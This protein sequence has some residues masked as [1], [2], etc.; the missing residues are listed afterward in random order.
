MTTEEFIDSIKLDGEEWRDVVGYEGYYIVSNFGRIAV[1]ERLVTR[2]HRNGKDANF[3]LK[4]HICSTSIAPST[5]YRR[6]TFKTKHKLK[7]TQLVHR[8]VAKAFLD[9]PNNYTCVDHI[10]DNPQNNYAS[11]LQWCDYKIN[12]AKEHHR[13]AVSKAKIGHIDPKR[14]PI[15]AIDDNNNIIN[16]SSVWEAH[17][18]GHHN[19]AILK[20]LN[21]KLHTHH[22]YK[23]M[24]LKD[25]N[26]LVNKSKNS[27][28]TL[29]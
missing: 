13:I 16:F 2:K 11:N 7:D 8:V 25:Y 15:V 28:S 14:K 21:G 19:S 17:L 1:L 4:P 3:I 9:N 5:K 22:G 6:M 26:S 23:W 27:Q 29:D 20:V 12:N 24:Y 10:D 18:Q